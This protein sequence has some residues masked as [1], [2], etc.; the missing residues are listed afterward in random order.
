MIN[1]IRRF[2]KL[3]FFEIKKLTRNVPVF[4]FLLL[5]PAV[6]ACAMGGLLSSETQAGNSFSKGGSENP[7]FNEIVF[8]CEDYEKIDEEVVKNL[9]YLLSNNSDQITWKTDL[10]KEVTNLELS[11]SALVIYVDVSTK[12]NEIAV[13]YNPINNKSNGYKNYITNKGYQYSYYSI[14][15]FISSW[16]ITVDDNILNATKFQSLNSQSNDSL[17]AANIFT[18][19]LIISFILVVGISYS[20]A[21]DNET[22]VIK[23]LCYTPMST[24][25]YLNIRAV[26]YIILGVLQCVVMFF[27]FNAFGTNG[28]HFW[29][30][31]GVFT[32]FV[33]AFS[34]LMFLLSTSKSQI[35][36]V[37]LAIVLIVGPVLLNFLIN[38]ETVNIFIKIIL[39]L[40]PVTNFML[41]YS[42]GLY[43]GI[44]AARHIIV[45]I[46]QI[47]VYYLLSVIVLKKKTGEKIIKKA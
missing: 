9:N 26:M 8:V 40:S 23:Q 11:N 18:T 35:G 42:S 46:A 12:P 21:R 27:I 47:I 2:F 6:L 10:S 30:C 34:M 37:C 17:M 19:V 32:L 15:E 22:G 39:Y 38:I 36:T 45:M 13:I 41:A 33:A 3:I 7:I 31:L 25:K 1:S 44:V 16:G 14:K 24:T 28:L 20:M 5:C 4:L 43:Y 29:Q